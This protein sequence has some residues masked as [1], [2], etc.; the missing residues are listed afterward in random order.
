M[1]ETETETESFADLT[2]A[3]IYNLDQTWIFETKTE[4][5][6]MVETESL[7][8]LNVASIYNLDQTWT[9]GPKPYLKIGDFPREGFWDL[10]DQFL[11]FETPTEQ[12]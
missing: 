5:R 9:Y 7:A 10:R 6:K 3:S 4:T 2:V 11:R 1:V 8:D 12:V